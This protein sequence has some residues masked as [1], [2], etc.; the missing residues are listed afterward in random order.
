MIL[1]LFISILILSRCRQTYS[2]SRAL[3][4][5]RGARVLV[6]GALDQGLIVR[7]R[8][9]GYWG[10]RVHFEASVWDSLPWLMMVSEGSVSLDKGT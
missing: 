2:V 10:V 9:C 3:C 7:C 8:A 4:L 6:Y 1:V 5:W